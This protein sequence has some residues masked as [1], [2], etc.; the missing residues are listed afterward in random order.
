MAKNSLTE[1]IKHLKYWRKAVWCYNLHHVNFPNTP[2]FRKMGTGSMVLVY[3]G[4]LRIG[5]QIFPHSWYT[6]S[7]LPDLRS[8]SG[9]SLV[10]PNSTSIRIPCSL[11]LPIWT[12][13]KQT[14]IKPDR[15]L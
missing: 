2:G 6:T 11:P 4:P 7:F 5:T 13:R 10:L 1:K 8:T 14:S 3:R 12:V 15:R 9:H